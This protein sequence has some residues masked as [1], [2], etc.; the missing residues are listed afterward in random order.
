MSKSTR[1]NGPTL[2]PTRTGKAVRAILLADDNADLRE[3]TAEQLEILGYAVTAVE[4]GVAALEKLGRPGSTYDALVTDV[5]MPRLDGV[6]LATRARAMQPGL[7]V[8]LISTHADEMVAERLAAGEVAFCRKPFS[9]EDLVAGLEAARAAAATLPAPAPKREEPSPMEA[10]MAGKAVSDPPL[11]RRV[12][13]VEAQAT[14]VVDEAVATT[15]RVRSERS[16]GPVPK[17]L[18]WAALLIVAIGVGTVLRRDSPP[19]LP[20]PIEDE[21]VRSIRVEPLFPQ[22][23]LEAAPETLAWREVDR[24]AIYRVVVR[25]MA[26]VPVWEAEVLASPTSVPESVVAAITPAVRYTWQVEALDRAGE[27]LAWS[28]PVS[29]IVEPG[30]VESGLGE[31][32]GEGMIEGGKTP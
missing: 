17:L 23:R 4:D 16:R 12:G 11:A 25:R 18:A 20:A 13:P 28:E 26:R 9:R 15:R 21:V 30:W 24:A 29:F 27:R 10:G 32:G 7:P 22:G 31:P 19:P 1:E 14:G 5:R 6:A 2:R 8:L 3:T